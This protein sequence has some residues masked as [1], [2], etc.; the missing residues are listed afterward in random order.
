MHLHKMLLLMALHD[1]QSTWPVLTQHMISQYTVALCVALPFFLQYM[2]LVGTLRVPWPPTL[3]LPIKALTWF[4]AASSSQ[5]LAL[6]CVI[7]QDNLPAAVPMAIARVLFYTLMPVGTF[8]VL[9][10]VEAAVRVLLAVLPP[11]LAEFAALCWRWQCMPACMSGWCSSKVVPHRGT[12]TVLLLKERLR[13]RFKRLHSIS[14]VMFFMCVFFFLPSVVRYILSLFVCVPLDDPQAPPYPWTAAAPGTYFLLDLNQQCWHGWHQVWALA[15]GIPVVFLLC[16]VLPCGLAALI[17]ANRKNLHAPSF[18]RRWGWVVRVYRPERAAWEAVVVCKTIGV[19]AVAVFGMALGTYH[20]TLL[21]A[22]IC[23]GFAVLLLVFKPHKH[24]ELQKLLV[25]AY[26]SLFITCLAALSF[27]PSFD[28]IIPP[29]AYSLAMGAVV[30]AANLTFV[31]WTLYLLKRAMEK[32]WP[33]DHIMRR[34]V[35]MATR[36]VP[37]PCLKCVGG[38]PGC[39]W[40]SPWLKSWQGVGGQQHMVR[41]QQWQAKGP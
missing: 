40:F 27:L 39:E 24:K 1:V 20:Q 38:L 11:L 23:A 4:L 9:W 6:E 15:Y 14:L 29:E 22:T 10:L 32:Q 31:A 37:E 36:L 19:C 34:A 26:S 5:T 21:M 2:V 41:Q 12:C 16:G 28:G 13:A 18:R 17:W 25:L 33:L 7:N 35:R 30:L 3:V 8:L